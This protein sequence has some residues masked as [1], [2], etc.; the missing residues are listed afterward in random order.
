MAADAVEVWR[1]CFTQW[2]ADVPRRGVVV[3]SFGDQI[4]FESFAASDDLLLIERR[5]PDT[6][7]AR[8]VIIAYQYIQAIKVVDVIKMKAFQSLGFTLPESRK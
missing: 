2:P 6:V 4:P 7:G 3:T 8:T 1:K 5:A